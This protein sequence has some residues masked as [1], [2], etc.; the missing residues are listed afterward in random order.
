[1]LFQF[2]ECH[3]FFSRRLLDKRFAYSYTAR[4]EESNGISHMYLASG[5]DTIVTPSSYI[6]QNQMGFH[7]SRSSW[8]NLCCV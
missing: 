5:P 6:L 3:N 7:Q 4:R 2:L 8:S 1:L